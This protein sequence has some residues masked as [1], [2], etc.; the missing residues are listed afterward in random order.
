MDGLARFVSRGLVFPKKESVNDNGSTDL[1]P[2]MEPTKMLAERRKLGQNDRCAIKTG[3]YDISRQMPLTAAAVQDPQIRQCANKIRKNFSE[4]GSGILNITAKRQWHI[5][6]EETSDI[7]QNVQALSDLIRSQHSSQSSLLRPL[8]LAELCANPKALYDEFQLLKAEKLIQYAGKVLK[9]LAASNSILVLMKHD[10]V[11]KCIQFCNVAKQA[12]SGSEIMSHHA[13]LQSVFKSRLGT[14]GPAAHTL[15]FLLDYFHVNVNGEATSPIQRN[16]NLAV[17]ETLG[18]VAERCQEVF[19]LYGWKEGKRPFPVRAPG[20][21][22]TQWS[23]QELQIEKSEE[24]SN[25]ILDNG[26]YFFTKDGRKLRKLPIDKERADSENPDAPEDGCTKPGYTRDRRAGRAAGKQMIFCLFC[27]FHSIQMGYHIV[28]K[29][30]GRKDPF[31]A[32][33]CHKPTCPH[34][35]S[36]DFCCG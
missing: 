25:P 2:T 36:Y 6:S 9:Q 35:T 18:F 22:W 33:F 1:E 32:I 7:S 23:D 30:E 27:V 34:S 5:R 3:G 4:L 16:V 11:E 12:S 15:C 31:Y 24:P 10:A 26:A 13:V 20:E 19:D 8:I 14:P 28:S 29:S 17:C 21:H